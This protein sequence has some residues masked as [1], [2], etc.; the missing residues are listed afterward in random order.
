MLAVLGDHRHAA[1]R[2][3]SVGPAETYQYFG[4]EDAGLLADRGRR[5]K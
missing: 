1:A 3:R 2:M 4:G 5:L